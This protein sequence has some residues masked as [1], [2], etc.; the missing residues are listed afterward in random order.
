MLSTVMRGLCLRS[1]VFQ[2]L[3]PLHHHTQHF[4]NTQVLITEAASARAEGEKQVE[5]R[6]IQDPRSRESFINSIKTQM[7]HANLPAALD[8]LQRAAKILS[9]SKKK[10]PS[11]IWNNIGALRFNVGVVKGVEVAYVLYRS[12]VFTF[13]FLF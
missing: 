8:A 7:I 6:Q 11:W 12:S 10:V 1:Y 2:V 5:E 4:A 3:N 9:N 13:F